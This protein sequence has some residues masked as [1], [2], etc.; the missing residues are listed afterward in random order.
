MQV[1]ARAPL[2]WALASLALVLVCSCGRPIRPRTDQ[3][4]TPGGL[5]LNYDMTLRPPPERKVDV[6]ARIDGIDPDCS[7]LRLKMSQD[8]AFVPAARRCN[9]AMRGA[10]P[11]SAR[12]TASAPSV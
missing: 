9:S 8:Y 2:W 3:P 10:A 5:R 11:S 1:R 6:V 4:A 12:V 7:E